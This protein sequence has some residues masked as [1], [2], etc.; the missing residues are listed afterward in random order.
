ML[1]KLRFHT[2]KAYV[3]LFI[4]NQDSLHI[5]ILI[6]VDNIII[7]SS[8]SSAIDKILQQLHHEFVVK[9]LARLN[10]FLGIEVYHNSS[11]LVLTQRKYIHDLLHA[12]M[13]TSKGVSMPMLPADKLSLHDG[14]CLS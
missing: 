2:S 9:N 8:S 3:S 10:Y 5:C 14:D 6:Y 13:D 12:N 7:V 4:F 1:I 11:G